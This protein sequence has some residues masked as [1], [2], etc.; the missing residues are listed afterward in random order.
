MIIGGGLAGLCCAIDLSKAGF[1]I[2]LIEKEAYP[3]HKV[4]GEYIS[5]EVLPYL[6][7]IG[8]DVFRL[9]A[10]SINRFQLSTRDSKLINAKLPLG[11]FGLSRFTMDAALAEIAGLNGVKIE[12]DLVEGLSFTGDAFQVIL[13]SGGWITSKLAIGAY[14]KR[15]N[16]DIKTKRSF[17][18]K[19]SPFL[20]VKIHVKGDFDDDLVALHNFDGGY[21]GVSKVENDMINLC[22]IATYESFKKYKEIDTFQREVVMK[23]VHLNRIFNKTIPLMDQPLTI[24]QIS[25][26]D[27]TKVDNHLLF[28]GDS[29]GMIHPL[30]GNGMG[31]AIR[32]A[33]MLSKIIKENL[34]SSN[35]YRENIED[36]YEKKWNNEFR[37]R[38]KVGR[39]VASI[40]AKPKLTAALMNG[41]NYFPFILPSIIKLTHGKVM[42]V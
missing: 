7:Y 4:C 42:E 37:L 5:N 31:M 9:G 1:S 3:K 23:N 12:K 10:T 30:C 32:S 14:G 36:Q 15:S 6:E 41:A 18:K 38:L 8:L 28:C 39:A 22:Y 11:G 26:A 17:V 25:F 40:F 16:L 2:C 21:C 24:S 35:N 34:Y 27:K 29:A 13:K 33:F 19:K 20:A